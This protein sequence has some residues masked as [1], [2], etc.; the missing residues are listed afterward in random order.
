[1]MTWPEWGV[2][3]LVVVVGCRLWRWWREKDSDAWWWM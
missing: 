2:L 1:M 3:A